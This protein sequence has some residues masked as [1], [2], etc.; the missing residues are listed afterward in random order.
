[1]KLKQILRT[2]HHSGINFPSFSNHSS[3]I[4][5]R[6]QK[7][8]SLFMPFLSLIIY[9]IIK[10][11]LIIMDKQD[12]QQIKHKGPD[13]FQKLLCHLNGELSF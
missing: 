11:L 3:S 4:Q 7:V 10:I 13:S 5:Y 12:F 8:H 6:K 9:M 2:L 1:M